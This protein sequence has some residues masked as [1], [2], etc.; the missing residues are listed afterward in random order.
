MDVYT[1]DLKRQAEI[2]SAPWDRET[3]DRLYQECL[4]ARAESNPESLLRACGADCP[5]ALVP[6][7]GRA[8]E[9]RHS[10]EIGC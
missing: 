9:S 2:E 4:A 7:A 5:G 3:A 10:S 6:N 8:I 1:C